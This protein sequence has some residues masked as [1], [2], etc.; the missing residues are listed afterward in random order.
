MVR[1]RCPGVAGVQKL[2]GRIHDTMKTVEHTADNLKHRHVSEAL[3]PP[4]R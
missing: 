1:T 2:A 4:P 3:V